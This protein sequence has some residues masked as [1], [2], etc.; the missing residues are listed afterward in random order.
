MP[1]LL[2]KGP[3]VLNAL[4]MQDSIKVDI[5]QVVEIL[6]EGSPQL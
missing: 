3:F 5:H 1:A 6:Q 2:G 4:G